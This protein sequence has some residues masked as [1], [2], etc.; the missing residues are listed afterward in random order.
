MAGGPQGGAESYFVKTAIA[1][2]EAGVD[3]KLVI[4]RNPERAALLR[5]AGLDPVELRFGGPLDIM[6]PRRLSAIARDY[7]PDVVLTWMSRASGRFPRGPWPQ[8][9]RLGNY[10]DL[11]Y[12]Q[13]CRELIG[14]TP[15]IAQ[16]CIEG[17][18]P[19]D[20]V[21]Y[22]PNF[23]LVRD[24]QPASRAAL[25]TPEDA[26]L[27]LALGRL[28]Y[29][30]AL[31]TALDALAAVPGV[32]LWIAGD[33]PLKDE[34]KAHAE[35]LGLI[36]RVRFLGWRED[37][38]ALLRASDICIFPSRIEPH[39]TVT[40][41]AWA[42]GVPLIAASAVGP[43]GLVDHGRTGLLFPIDDVGA[44]ASAIRRMIDD[45]ESARA[46]AKAGLETYQA[47]HSEEAV[48]QR[49]IEVLEGAASR[50]RDDFANMSLSTP[51]KLVQ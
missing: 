34:L 11:K 3:Q 45:P 38:S 12:F 5:D 37:A 17:G 33:G 35:R 10:Y 1:L 43:A 15:A 50:Y 27:L 36:D 41:E 47:S 2:A 14:I 30:K 18:W 44:L 28:H 32:Y 19:S 13:H 6:T 7:R 24:E 29:N 25:D 16:Y 51:Q 8:L 22:I 46:M 42:H 40:L 4:G 9:A 49:Y 21:H 26:P 23:G 48:T 20:R 31:D 39:G